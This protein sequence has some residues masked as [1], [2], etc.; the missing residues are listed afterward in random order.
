[1]AAAARRGDGRAAAGAGGRARRRVDRLRGV[2]GL[3]IERALHGVAGKGE[4]LE[5]MVE[6]FVATYAR[7]APELAATGQGDDAARWR[8]TSHSVR[9]ALAAIGAFELAGQAQAF[10]DAIAASAMA[11]LPLQLQALQLQAQL[12]A[13]VERLAQA[14]AAAG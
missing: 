6:S 4:L 7:G 10:E 5:R 1:V 3:D 11:G 9:G 13:L 14:V 8:A 12:V 2:A